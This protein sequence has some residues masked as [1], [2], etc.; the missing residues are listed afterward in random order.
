MVE[1]CQQT[2]DDRDILC[3]VEPCDAVGD[4]LADVREMRCLTLDD[5]AKDYHGVE[6]IVLA[7]LLCTVDELETARNGLHMDILGY[8][9]VLLKGLD[10]TLEERTGD[11]VIPLGYDN[12][13]THITCVW[14]TVE[15]VIG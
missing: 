4:S 3:G 10:T 11:V 15:V 14:H 12:A 13:E 5:A 7:H 8:G 1:S 2:V 9:T 6:T